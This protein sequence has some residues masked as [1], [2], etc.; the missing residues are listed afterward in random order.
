VL[1]LVAFL[2]ERGVKEPFLI[3][4]PAAVVANWEREVAAWL[5]DLACVAYKGNADMRAD[6]FQS[7]ARMC[8]ERASRL[9]LQSLTNSH[10]AHSAPI[11]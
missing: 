9:E 10:G 8:F 1:A 7:Q 11:E 3:A 5:P 4:A 6:I 2:V